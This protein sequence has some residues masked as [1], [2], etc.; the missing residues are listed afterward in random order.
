MGVIVA[1]MIA[2]MNMMVRWIIRKEEGRRYKTVLLAVIQY[3]RQ[4]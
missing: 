3:Y 4:C 2:V 1:L